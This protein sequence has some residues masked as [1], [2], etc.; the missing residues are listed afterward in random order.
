[1]TPPYRPHSPSSLAHPTPANYFQREDD[2]FIAPNTTAISEH[3]SKS[4]HMNRKDK[5][6]KR[7]TRPRRPFHR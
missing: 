2:N 7:R 6:G 4:P 3:V 5:A 1:M